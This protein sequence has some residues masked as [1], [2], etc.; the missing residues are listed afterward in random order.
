MISEELKRKVRQAEAIEKA[1]EICEK[2]QYY[3]ME[4]CDRIGGF[5]IQEPC[6][7]ASENWADIVEELKIQLGDLQ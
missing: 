5:G 1:I 6:G 4:A 3:V 2:A 7:H